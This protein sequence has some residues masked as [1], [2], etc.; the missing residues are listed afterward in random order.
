MEVHLHAPPE[1]ERV[2]EGQGQAGVQRRK[3]EV[4]EDFD[5]RIVTDIRRRSV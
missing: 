2:A 5:K 1:G 3:Q 4:Y